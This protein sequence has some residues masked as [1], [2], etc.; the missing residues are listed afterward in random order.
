MPRS[1]RKPK[2]IE[3]DPLEVARQL[4]VIECGLF[5][6][7]KVRFYIAS[8]PCRLPTSLSVSLFPSPFPLFF[9]ISLSF[10]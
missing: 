10:E 3:F 2:L 4:T 9:T 5:M 7:I 8:S 1:N 6:K